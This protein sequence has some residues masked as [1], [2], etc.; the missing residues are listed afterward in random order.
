M[1]KKQQNRPFKQPLTKDALAASKTVALPLLCSLLMFVTS[2]LPLT[3]SLLEPLQV[4]SPVYIDPTSISP[5]T[6][7]EPVVVRYG[8]GCASTEFRI[9]TIVDQDA[10]TALAWRVDF[11]AADRS[12]EQVGSGTLVST[13]EDTPT[14][15][16]GPCLSL[17]NLESRPASCDDANPVR[18]ENLNDDVYLLRFSVTDGTFEDRRNPDDIRPSDANLDFFKWPFSIDKEGPCDAE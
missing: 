3:P 17:G 18:V 5:Q 12:P 15:F 14:F 9:N 1:Q 13:N 2:C 4:G 8:S 11:Y 7:F 16:S 6:G 10:P